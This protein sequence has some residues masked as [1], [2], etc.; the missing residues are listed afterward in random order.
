M[1]DPVVVVHGGCGNV[2]DGRVRDEDAYHAALAEALMAASAALTA[3]AGALGA[4][5]A[6]VSRLE[7]APLFNAGRGSVLTTD[8]SVEMDAALACGRTGRSGGV[9]AVTRVRHPIAL[10]R[11]V[12]DATPHA[13]MAAPGAERLAAEHDLVLMD[14]GWFVTDR[15]RERLARAQAASA[16][17]DSAK[18]TVGAVVL[19]AD[20]ALAAATSSGGVTGQLPGRIG[21][22][23]IVGAGTYADER[24][25]VS[26]TGSGEAILQSGAAHEIA[27]LIRHAGLDLAQACERVVGEI[28]GD[29]GV[30]AVDAAGSFAMPHN[31]NLMH[32][33]HRVGD[34]EPHTAVLAR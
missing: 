6:A 19:D 23:P 27:A 29:A 30:I 15:Q 24:V 13:L 28:E 34:G 3:G 9:A 10:A 32:R 14:P 16:E 5:Q 2:A 4:V 17:D 26:M 31:T 7:D 25:A 33:G 21:D 22:S 18:G 11:V 8:G 1:P 12:M 20:G